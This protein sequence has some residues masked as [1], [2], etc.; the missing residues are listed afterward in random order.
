MYKACFCP[1]EKA[2]I[3]VGKRQADAVCWQLLHSSMSA[4]SVVV[5]AAAASADGEVDIQHPAVLLGRNKSAT[6][7]A[8]ARSLCPAT[9]FLG[10]KLISVSHMLSTVYMKRGGHLFAAADAIVG[11]KFS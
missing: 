8:A 9:P 10:L 7:G 6:R 5:V 1:G 11:R 3:V 4:D 2:T